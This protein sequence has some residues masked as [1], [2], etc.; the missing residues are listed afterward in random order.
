MLG[1]STRRLITTPRDSV[2]A[3]ADRDCGRLLH[4]SEHGHAPDIHARELG[5]ATDD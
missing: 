4:G 3:A 5:D 2:L 1:L